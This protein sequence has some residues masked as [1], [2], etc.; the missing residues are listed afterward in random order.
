MLGTSSACT[1]FCN[2]A[3]AAFHFACFVP[4][5]LTLTSVTPHSLP[6][7]SQAW[8]LF[9]LHG[10][11]YRRSRCLPMHRIGTILTCI[12]FCYA[13]LAAFRFTILLPLQLSLTSCNASLAA[14]Q[15]TSLVPL[16][17]AL[18]SVTPHSLPSISQAWYL[19]SLY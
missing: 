6:S 3:L 10:L 8:Y 19:F 14:F 2:T 5:Q 15:F 17:L 4:L 13:A 9:S 7:S 18:T 11:L 12:G 16:Q 1:D